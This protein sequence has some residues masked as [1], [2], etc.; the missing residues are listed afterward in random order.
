MNSGKRQNIVVLPTSCAPIWRAWYDDAVTPAPEMATY[1]V[2]LEDMP[3]PEL[4]V[5]PQY[6]VIAEKFEAI[7]S[8]GMANSRMKDYFD[9][10]VLLRKTNIEDETLNQAVR[11]TFKNRG[12]A[13]PKQ[14]PAGL[15]DRFAQDKTRMA[16]WDAFISRNKLEAESLLGTV[17]YLRDR[18]SLAIKGF[19]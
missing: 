1:P 12:T 10:W 9:L 17:L 15:S 3:A 13:M 14:V 19:C 4:R 8:P 11:A 18:L 7:V 16:L 2:M 5:Y 6:T